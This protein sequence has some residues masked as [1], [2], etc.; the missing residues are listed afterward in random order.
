MRMPS[1]PMAPTAIAI[2]AM[3]AANGGCGSEDPPSASE[4][5]PLTMNHPPPP[6]PESKEACNAC[7]GLW[8]TQ[9]IAEVESCICRTSD[10][11]RECRDGAECDGV[12][13]VDDRAQFEAV[14][15]DPALGSFVGRCSDYD[16]L[17]GCYRILPVGSSERAALP[18]DDAAD[19]ICVD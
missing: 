12:C 2:F 7:G 6:R 3:L 17:F 8:G 11:G 18:A 15:T 13:L 9:G 14:N 10:G 16:T 1:H 4:S 19:D 5:K